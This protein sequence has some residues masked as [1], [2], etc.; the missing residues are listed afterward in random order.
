VLLALV[1]IGAAGC[2]DEGRQ[3]EAGAAAPTAGGGA[4]PGGPASGEIAARRA[5]RI[6]AK[7]VPPRSVLGSDPDPKSP[8]LVFQ[9][10]E[11]PAKLL[12]WFRATGNGADFVL[13]SEMQE[14]AEHVFSGRVRATG[15]AFTVRIAPGASGGTTG[16]VMVTAR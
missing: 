3:R 5:S 4:T 2:R 6:E 7:L 1:L 14:G 16:M 15:E 13:E 12:D 11:A 9:A 10:Q 8:G